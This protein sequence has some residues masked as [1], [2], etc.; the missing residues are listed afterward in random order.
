MTA[1]GVP[2]DVVAEL[3]ARHGEA[4]RAYHNWAHV[5]ALL[6]WF[7]EV[8]SELHDPEAVKLA[9]FFHDAVY[10]P[11]RGDNEAESA[12]L[13][14]S[15]MAGRVAPETLARAVRLVEATHKHLVP[16]GLSE[17][18]ASDA[19]V[20]LDMDLSI[21]GAPEPVFDRYERDIR[22]E[23]VH[24]PEDA[25]RQ[26]RAA[27]LRRFAERERLYFSTWGRDRFEAAARANIARSIAK[28][29]ADA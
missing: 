11:T 19:A 18:D 7:A 25:F 21:L 28:L 8:E 16:E 3:K 26:G 12:A 22:T 1:G 29:G 27:V 4:G 9:V 6:R 15:R 5:E 10:E 2:D 13:L 24:V 14:R 17:A 23:Y 20:F